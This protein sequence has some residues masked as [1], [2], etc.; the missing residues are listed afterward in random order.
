M[1]PNS[2]KK[3]TGP[4][5]N[6]ALRLKGNSDISALLDG[7]DPAATIGGPVP[8]ADPFLS[9]IDVTNTDVESALLL[10][11]PYNVNQAAIMM[12]KLGPTT[13]M[14]KRKAV[15]LRH[16][17]VQESLADSSVDDNL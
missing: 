1:S 16:D 12:P 5:R 3:H 17:V 4:S 14:K 2:F 10:S 11:Q 8:A 15:P 6:Q 7:K 13:I 9:T